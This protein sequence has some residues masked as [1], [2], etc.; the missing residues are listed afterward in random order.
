MLWATMSHSIW[1]KNVEVNKNVDFEMLGI[2]LFEIDHVLKQCYLQRK[3][4]LTRH[5]FLNL[6]L[7]RNHSITIGRRNM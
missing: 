2:I 5:S 1:Q 3:Y 6:M 4:P 7:K